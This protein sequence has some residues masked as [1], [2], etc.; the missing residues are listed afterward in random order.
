MWVNLLSLPGIALPNGIQIVARRF[1][2]ADMF[3]AASAV[4]RE[5]GPLSIAVSDGDPSE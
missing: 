4:E 3:D 1:H 5:L 2:E